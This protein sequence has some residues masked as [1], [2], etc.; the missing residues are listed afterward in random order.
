MQLHAIRKGV[1]LLVSF[2]F[3]GIAQAQFLETDIGLSYFCIQPFEHMGYYIPYSNGG[4]FIF[5]H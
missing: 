3:N 5:M 1:L 2:L 4:G